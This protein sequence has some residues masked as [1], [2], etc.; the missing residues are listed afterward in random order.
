MKKP[1][2]MKVKVNPTEL[3]YMEEFLKTVKLNTVCQSAH[4]PN[5][6]ECFSRKTATF[7]I[8]GNVC[9]RNCRFCAVDKGHPMPLDDDEPMRVAEAA[10]ALNLKHAVIT[11][12]TRD[13]LPDGGAS[14]FARTVRELKKIPGLTVEVLVSDFRGNEEAIRTVVESK[15]DVINHNLETVPRLYPAVRPMADYERSL[16]LLKKVKELDSAIYT[17]S[18][19]MVGLGETEEEVVDLMKDLI[20]VSCDMMTIGQYLRPSLSHIAVVEY[21]TPEQFERYRKIGYGLGFKYVA[22]GPLVR[23]SYNAAEGID[24][25]KESAFR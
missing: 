23:S 17:K 11:C 9:T 12:V 19:I 16:F 21:V 1:E 18:G 6:G 13:D 24:A 22:S 25:I 5:M 8:M 10:R 7:M 14:H 15:P 3:K 4:C 20:S 2:W